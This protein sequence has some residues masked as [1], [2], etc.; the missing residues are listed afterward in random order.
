MKTHQ[1]S[2]EEPEDNYQIIAIYTDEQDYRL[3]FLL[4][5]YL[6][7]QLVKSSSIIDKITKT[8]FTVFEYED[9]NLFQNWLLLNNHCFVISEINKKKTVDLFNDKP[10]IFKKKKHY[11]HTYKKANFLL[12][13]I[14]EI[15][16]QASQ[17]LI[18]TI[19]EIPQIYAVE[20]LLLNKIKNKKL[21]KF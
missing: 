8:D 7:L 9:T 16:E 5:Q 4:N 12:K 15:D 6:N 11:L 18:K 21:L 13:L 20:L 1:L 17:K 19:E 3:A 14:A 10:A 2:V